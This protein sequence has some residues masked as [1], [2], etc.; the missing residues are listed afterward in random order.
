MVLGMFGQWQKEGHTMMVALRL[1]VGQ[2]AEYD[3]EKSLLGGI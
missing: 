1:V 3:T 2:G